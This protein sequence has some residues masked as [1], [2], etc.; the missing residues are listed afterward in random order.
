MVSIILNHLQWY[1][2]GFDIVAARGSLFVSAAEGF[3]IISGILLGIVRGRNMFQLPFKTNL[4]NGVFFLYIFLLT[5]YLYLNIAV[6]IL[7]MF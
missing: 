6:N 7:F 3:F 2:S 1:P 4:K 5:V